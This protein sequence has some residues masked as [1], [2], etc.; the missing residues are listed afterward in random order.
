MLARSAAKHT[1]LKDIQ[2]VPVGV[3]YEDYVQFRRQLRVRT[4]QA[5]PFADLLS[6]DGTLDK[7]AFNERLRKA[8]GALVMDIQPEEAQPYFH[9]A[10]RAMRPT[11]QCLDSWKSMPELLAKWAEKWND[12]A[13]KTQVKARFEAFDAAWKQTGHVGRPEAWGRSMEDVRRARPWI[14]LLSLLS[15]VGNFPSLPGELLIK[16]IVRKTVKKPEFIS[17]MSLGYGIVLL[18]LTWFLW[19]I[20]AATFAPTGLGWV[21]AAATWCWSQAGSRFHAWHASE[22]HD[23]RDQRDGHSF[24]NDDANRTLRERWTA[25]LQAFEG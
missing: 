10:A 23:W 3:E 16:R 8:L 19:S 5:V 2:V 17:T 1:E 9:P 6:D 7:R 21:A 18:P 12:E 14:P 15:W 25:Y 22:M 20:L 11:E 13:W 4:G 24:W